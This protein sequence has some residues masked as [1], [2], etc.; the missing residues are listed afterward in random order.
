MLYA[1][2]ADR[3]IKVRT[4]TAPKLTQPLRANAVFPAI[5][6]IPL[7]IWVLFISDIQGDIEM[8]V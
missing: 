4:F 3:A 5:E 8:C 2:L 6:S 7:N 1:G